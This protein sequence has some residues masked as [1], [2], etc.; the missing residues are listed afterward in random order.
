[1]RDNAPGFH[2]DVYQID[3]CLDSISVAVTV[4]TF[5]TKHPRLRWPSWLKPAVRVAVCHTKIVFVCTTTPS[6]VCYFLSRGFRFRLQR[7]G[8][9]AEVAAR[10]AGGARRQQ[11]L[12]R[13]R[14]RQVRLT[15]PEGVPP[16]GAGCVCVPVRVGGWVGVWVGVVCVCVPG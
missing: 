14:V 4:N 1:M 6:P 7:R 13:R 5:M 11:Q 3:N 2:P 12:E 9:A 10:D 8:C 16:A 15:H